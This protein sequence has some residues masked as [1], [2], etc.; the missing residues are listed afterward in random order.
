M[1]VNRLPQFG[2]YYCTSYVGTLEE[3][4]QDEAEKRMQQEK[5]RGD[6]D[7]GAKTHSRSFFLFFVLPWGG[8]KKLG[9]R[10]AIK[11]ILQRHEKRTREAA[12]SRRLKKQSHLWPLVRSLL[13]LSHEFPSRASSRDSGGRKNLSSNFVTRSTSTSHASRSKRGPRPWITSSTLVVFFVPFFFSSRLQLWPER[14]GES[15][16]SFLE[17][18]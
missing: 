7:R 14:N 13:G 2:Q 10:D 12:F 8:G 9:E 18:P 1:G 6:E 16:K 11:D 4:G 3:V 5:R 17:M 15:S